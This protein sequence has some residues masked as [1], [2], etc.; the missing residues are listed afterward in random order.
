[1]TTL[2]PRTA[3]LDHVGEKQLPDEFVTDIERWKTRS[4]RREGQ[5]GPRPA[6]ELHRRPR[7]SVTCPSTSPAPSRWRRPWTSSR[8]RSSTPAK[9]GPRCAPFSDGV[10]PTTLDKT[11]NPDGTH[12]FSH[13]HAVGPAHLVGGAAPRGARG[14]RR[15][16]GRPVRRAGTRPQGLGHRTRRRRPARDGAGVRPGRRQHLPRRAQRRAAVPHAAGARLR[17]LPDPD[18]GPLQRELRDPRRRR[19]LRHPRPAGVARPR[20]GTPVA[21]GAPRW[22]GSGAASGDA[23]PPARAGRSVRGGRRQR[24]SRLVRLADGDRG[25]AQPGRRAR[26]PG[27]PRL[28]H[29]ARAAAACRRWPTS[30]SRSTWC[31]SASPDAQLADHLARARGARRG[32][33]GGLR[34]R[35]TAAADELVAAADGLELCGGGCMG[36]VNVSRRRP[37]DRL[38]RARPAAR[39]AGS[40]W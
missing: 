37:R 21:A 8:R 26:L 27:Q 11:L 31:C 13:V 18:R 4:R 16:A 29:G 38:P 10:I 35:G 22:R 2:H 20:S 28:R 39:R 34:Q 3:F 7:T 25:A 32:R 14:V 24:P 23:R 1:M 33:C 17:R 6:A 19:G 5:P 12:V 36:F 30:P 15:P 9:A 40:R